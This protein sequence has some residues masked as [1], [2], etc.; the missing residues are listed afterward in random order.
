MLRL[1]SDSRHWRMA[2]QPKLRHRLV[3]FISFYLTFKEKFVVN[4]EL[5]WS[6]EFL[7]F[8]VQQSLTN[9]ISASSGLKQTASSKLNPTAQPLNL[10]CKFMADRTVFFYLVHI[11]YESLWCRSVVGHILSSILIFL[12]S[13]TNTVAQQA[14]N[15]ST[16]GLPQLIA[17]AQGQIIA[18]NTNSVCTLLKT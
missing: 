5:L 4:P 13:T 2:S 7:F 6:K 17:N 12:A 18:I 8:Q 10:S 9:G 16:G 3:Y 1:Y 15:Q 11:Y 14:V